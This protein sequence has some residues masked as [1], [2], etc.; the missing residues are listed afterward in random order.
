MTHGDFT[1]S[2]GSAYP[3]GA[4]WD[5]RGV[6]FALFSAHAERVE[7]CLFDRKGR[8]EIQKLTLPD[9]TDQVWHGY[10]PEAR[11][12]QLYG[13]R[14]HG[15]YC[16]EEGHR[17]NP[18]KLLIDPYARRLQGTIKWS[19]AHYGY[20]ANSPREDLSFDRRDSAFAMPKCVVVDE[21]FSWEGDRRRLVPWSDTIIYE[22]HVRGF[23]RRR[24]EIP[25]QLRGTFAGLADPVSINY[26]KSLGI[27]TVELLPVFAF[28]DDRFLEKKGLR[29]YWGYQPI[30]FFA[31]EQRYQSTGIHDFKSMVARLHDAG[32]EVILDV[33]Y[34]HTAEGSHLGPT[35]SLRGIDNHSYY[36]LAHDQKRYYSNL[37]GCGN[38][39]DV[40]HPRVLQMVMDSMR[41]WVTQMHVDGFRFDLATTLGREHHGFDQGAGFF[42]VLRQDPI[43]AGVKLIAEPWDVGDGGYQ[44]GN[45][46]SGWA[47][48]NDRV[49]DTVRRYWRGDQSQLPHLSKCLHGS[50]DL[51]EKPG[52]AVWAGVNYVSCHDGFTLADIVSYNQR[53]NHA[54]GEDNRDG[55]AEPYSHNHGVEGPTEDV[56][57][58]EL[59]RRQRRNLLAT[60]FLAQGTPMLQA[61]DEIGRSQHG[62]NNAYCQDNDISWLQWQ[63]VDRD[64]ESFL[65]FVKHLIQVRKTY[66]VLRRPWFMHG[67]KVSKNTGLSDLSWFNAQGEPMTR[68]NWESPNGHAVAMALAGDVGPDGPNYAVVEEQDSLLAV[69]NAGSKKTQFRTPEVR[70]P[71]NWRCVLDTA[72]PARPQGSLSVPAGALFLAAARS[73]YLFVLEPQEIKEAS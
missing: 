53:H 48:W 30:S 44:V 7:L 12:G 42:D 55:H 33:V 66:G 2:K 68:E 38:A 18:N 14:V 9:Y 4:T 51:F 8:K 37:S 20:I 16:P 49:R 15:P 26:L 10:V 67:R 56:D 41:Y 73:V 62:N 58:K 46:P 60:V 5:G 61:G 40:S 36:R 34:N 52:R 21:A 57:I 72:D 27:T 45:F 59:R 19:D 17:F 25:K 64:E 11:P 32:I 1:I 28:A 54:N 39:L 24:E 6:N 69:F 65:A 31:P 70:T 13:Y 23:T 29:N 35:L 22:L 63:K 43:L 47:E 50:G 3:L 71:H